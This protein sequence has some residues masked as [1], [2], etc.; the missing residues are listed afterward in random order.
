VDILGDIPIYVH[1]D[2][3][4]VWRYPKNFK[5]DE[6]FEPRFVAGAPP[7]F[8]SADGQRWG[9]PVYD[10]PRMQQDGFSWWVSR[11]HFNLQLY[12]WVRIDHFRGLI[13]YWEI[14]SRERTA[15]KGKWVDVPTDEFFKALREDQPQMPLIAED[16]GIMTEEVHRKI[17]ATGIPGMKILLFAF[18]SDMH[19]NP[20]LPH[21]F[22]EHCVVY[23]GTHDNNTA[24]GWFKGLPDWQRHNVINYL[25][26]SL[27]LSHDINTDEIH[28]Y[29]VELAARSRARWAIYP[30]QD[31]LGC[32]EKGRMNI[33]G[34]KKGNWRW[35]FLAEDLTP[36]IREKLT[37][38]TQLSHRAYDSSQHRI[39]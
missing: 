29:L 5:L 34:T 39:L 37:Q 28:W 4:D 12:D 19:T 33:P 36:A 8:F 11:V 20:Y 22:G 24:R 25:K 21:N 14:P 23:T 6:R 38:L 15:R 10:W 9:N 3:V 32:D 16:L 2:S 35:R 7:D 27:K 30:L 18:D 17:V 31:I 13:N 1:L 26:S